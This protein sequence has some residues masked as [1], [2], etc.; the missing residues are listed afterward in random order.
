VKNGF[1]APLKTFCK[2]YRFCSNFSFH[3][4]LINSLSKRRPDNSMNAKNRRDARHIRDVNNRRGTKNGRKPGREKMSKTA[5]SS[6]TA[7]M[8]NK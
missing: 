1:F 7:L 3:A 4:P 5:G 8:P 2:E 6:K